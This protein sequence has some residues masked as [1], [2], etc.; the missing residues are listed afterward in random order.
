MTPPIPEVTPRTFRALPF[1]PDQGLPQSATVTVGSRSYDVT[2]Y[3]N[4]DAEDAAP[5]ST[6]YDLSSPGS[7]R[8]PTAAPGFLVLRIDR[9]GAAGDETILLRKVVPDPGLIHEAGDLA[10]VVR[11]ARIAKGNLNGR[12]RLGSE[13]SIGVA[14]RW[15]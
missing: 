1:D 14:P 7:V 12:G 13:L 8:A 11:R 4:L 2:L 6:I 9:R 5:P 15:E 10:V 3:A